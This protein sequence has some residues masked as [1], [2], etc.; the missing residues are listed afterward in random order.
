M[1]EVIPSA[2][3][4]FLSVRQS[5]CQSACL[6][7][8][9]CLRESRICR[10]SF[11]RISWTKVSESITYETKMKWWNVEHDPTTS[12]AMS[13]EWVILYASISIF[14]HHNGRTK[15]T[16]QQQQVTKLCGRPPQYA[17]APCKLTFDLLTLKVCP[18]HCDVGYHCANFSLPRPFCSWLRPDERDRQTSDTHHPLNASALWGREHKKEAHEDTHTRTSVSDAKAVVNKVKQR[19]Y[20]LCCL[21]ASTINHYD[22]AE[23][24]SVVAIHNTL[25]YVRSCRVT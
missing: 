9:V 25:N 17:P 3:L 11:G 1:E 23:I 4:V 22:Y 13:S 10:E 21:L 8:S 15:T 19:D 7:L 16:K 5:F 6:L 14:I 12:C 24:N 2:G 18:S 20:T